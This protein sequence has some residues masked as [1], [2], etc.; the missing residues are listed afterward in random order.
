MINFFRSSQDGESM[1][2]PTNRV[3]P[4][5]WRMKN[6]VFCHVSLLVWAYRAPRVEYNSEL[7]WL[8]SNNFLMSFSSLVSLL[9][10]L[11]SPVSLL[12]F[13]FYFICVCCICYLSPLW[14]QVKLWTCIIIWPM[15]FL[16]IRLTAVSG[17]IDGI[18]ITYQNRNV[19]PVNHLTSLW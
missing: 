5:Y 3:V 7:L 11:T 18:E 12:C 19:T 13:V 16:S 15:Y 17:C 1:P 2:L 4:S 8:S 6:K 14:A 10:V 9:C